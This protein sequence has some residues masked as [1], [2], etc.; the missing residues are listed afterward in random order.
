[1][2]RSV[3]F[4]VAVLCLTTLATQPAHAVPTICQDG[5]CYEES[6]PPDDDDEMLTGGTVQL[7]SP[8]RQGN[9]VHDYVCRWDSDG[10]NKVCLALIYR[11]CDPYAYPSLG[12][13]ARTTCKTCV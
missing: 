2:K 1:M 5:T 4:A 8:Q 3:L 9:V 12:G 13:E 11:R 6:P 10:V 7:C